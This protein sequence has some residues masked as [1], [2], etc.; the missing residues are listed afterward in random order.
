M[1]GLKVDLKKFAFNHQD[2]I[3]KCVLCKEPL[4]DKYGHNPSPLANDGRC[5]EECN[6]FHVI[7]TRM[8]QAFNKLGGE[9]EE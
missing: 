4:G 8:A 1:G 7:P 9:S 6:F 2:P 5:C 3:E